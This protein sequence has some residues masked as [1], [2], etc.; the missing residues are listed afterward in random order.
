MGPLCAP[1]T[2]SEHAAF[3]DALENNNYGDSEAWEKISQAIGTGRASGEVMLH[4][5]QYLVK[6]QVLVTI[7]LVVGF[8]V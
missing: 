6:L 2:A 4:A 1:F 7:W 8:R 3:V 5:Y